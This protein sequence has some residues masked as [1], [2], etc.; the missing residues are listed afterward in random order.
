ME[1]TGST[2]VLKSGLCQV[3]GTSGKASARWISALS[4]SSPPRCSDSRASRANICC[5]TEAQFEM[6]G[7]GIVPNCVLHVLLAGG[8]LAHSRE[9]G[10]RSSRW[11]RSRRA[12]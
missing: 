5:A 9:R 8:F 11:G 2:S 6:K 3:L 1:N 4:L 12:S 7:S 10:P